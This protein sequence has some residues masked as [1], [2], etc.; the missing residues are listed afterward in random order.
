MKAKIFLTFGIILL[1]ALPVAADTLFLKN[2]EKISGLI[3]TQGKRYIEL[4]VGCGVVRFGK[5]EIERI[6]YSTPEES[7]GILQKWQASKDRSRLIEIDASQLRDFLSQESEKRIS[8]EQEEERTKNENMSRT[9]RAVQKGNQVIVLAKLN[10]SVP[11]TLV[12]DTGASV[13]VLTKQIAEQAG[14]NLNLIEDV[15]EVELADGSKTK[16]KQAV[17]KSLEVEGNRAENVVVAILL[18]EPEKSHLE[19]GLLGMSYLN[20]FNFTLNHENGELVFKKAP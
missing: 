2:G 19:D 4:N 3:K 5:N 1:S 16:V 8:R 15:I 17:L 6:Y 11:A 10:D 20:R 14:I 9:V 12:L 7:I 13:V 18:E